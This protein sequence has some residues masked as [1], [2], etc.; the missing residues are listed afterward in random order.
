MGQV[1]ATH[2]E[3]EGRV[4]EEAAR[5][6]R[7]VL[8]GAGDISLAQI[9]SALSSDTRNGHRAAGSR[10]I[11]RDRPHQPRWVRTVA[12]TGEARAASHART[13]AC[14]Q[15]GIAGGEQAF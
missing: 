5:V 11:L 9:S 4:A 12:S 8:Q 13:S 2:F 3:V 14:V 1:C 15:N 10:G 7:K 6:L